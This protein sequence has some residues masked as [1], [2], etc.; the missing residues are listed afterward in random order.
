MIRWVSA[1]TRGLSR[2]FLVEE[3]WDTSFIYGSCVWELHPTSKPSVINALKKK[4]PLGWLIGRFDSS[5]G[6][7]A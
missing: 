4:T 2:A 7:N 1:N 5:Q 6:R 3:Y